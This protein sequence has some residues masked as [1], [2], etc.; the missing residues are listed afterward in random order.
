MDEKKILDALHDHYKESIFITDGEG[1]VIYVNKVAADRLNITCDELLGK[2]V[3]ELLSAGIYEK[4]TVLDA[5]KTKH[6]IAGPIIENSDHLSFSNSVPVLDEDGNVEMVV[7]N[8]MNLEHQA[9]WASVMRDAKAE[10]DKL[11]REREY[12]RLHDKRVM[13]A[14][15]PMMKNV[16]T[17]VNALAPTDSNV[18]LLGESGTGKDMMANLIHEKSNRS[19]GAFISVNCAAMP[20][21]LLESELFGY[22]PGAFTGALKAGKIGLFEA[23]SGGTL[24]LDEIGD[25][26]PALQSKLLRVLENQEVRRVGGVRNIPVDVRIICATN[27]D[28]KLLVNQRKFREDLYYRLSVFTIELPALKNRCEDIIP[29]AEMF[30]D[31][32][33]EKY[34]GKK[35]LSTITKETMLNYDWPG[36]IR[37]MRNVIERIYV[38]SKGDELIFTPM[39]RAGYAEYPEENTALFDMGKYSSLRDFISAAEMHYIKATLRECSGSV[40]RTAEKL[41]IHRSVLYRKLHKK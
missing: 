16:L 34:G 33:N 13:I 38:V 5:I 2:T 17:T 37:E 12:L 24:F 20:A 23:T 31:G 4:S 6:P 28:L 18:V 26:S 29:I 7:T 36:N 14:D 3:R 1:R 9:E 32:L 22:E 19:D 27:M 15:S 8:N 21:S 41:G 35:Y 25:M 11:R 10:S 30:L 39:P 40:N